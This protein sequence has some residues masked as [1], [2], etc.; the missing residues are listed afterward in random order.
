MVYTGDS[1]LIQTSLYLREACFYHPAGY[2]GSLT[3]VLN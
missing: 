1:T 3:S 2:S